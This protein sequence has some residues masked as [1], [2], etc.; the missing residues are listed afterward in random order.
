MRQARALGCEHAVL[1]SPNLVLPET[2]LQHH[3]RPVFAV[4]TVRVPA[5]T[6]LA[7][8]MKLGITG[9]REDLTDTQLRW[10]RCGMGLRFQRRTGRALRDETLA[11]ASRIWAGGGDAELHVWVP[12]TVLESGWLFRIQLMVRATGMWVCQHAAAYSA[13]VR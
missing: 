13:G 9:T 8:D 7:A 1:Q 3:I 10:L 12:V 6:S 2:P 5:Q 11:F 4:Q